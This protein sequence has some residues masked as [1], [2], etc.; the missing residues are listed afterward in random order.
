[1]QSAQRAA[2]TAAVTVVAR[3]LAAR[4]GTNTEYDPALGDLT[5]GLLGLDRAEVARILSADSP[6]RSDRPGGPPDQLR[7]SASR[8]PKPSST[9]PVTASRRRRT[10]RRAIS[11]R[12]R[13]S[14]STSATE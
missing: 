3:H 10:A 5:S 8:A 6:R 7:S 4:P 2:M 12:A 11:R 9:T 13:A 14:S 1:M